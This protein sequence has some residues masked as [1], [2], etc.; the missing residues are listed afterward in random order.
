MSS[1]PP[2]QGDDLNF[3][4]KR[5]SNPT[6]EQQIIAAFGRP[7]LTK[8]DESLMEDIRAK[9]KRDQKAR[10]E[11]FQ[12][13]RKPIPLPTEHE[14]DVIL[15]GFYTT[16]VESPGHVEMHFV[17][18]SREEGLVF[19]LS[20]TSLD[21]LKKPIAWLTEYKENT[22][23]I[24]SEREFVSHYIVEQLHAYFQSIADAW[25]AMYTLVTIRPRLT[26]SECAFDIVK[27]LRLFEK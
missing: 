27:S 12:E 5:V 21:W 2:A 23:E 25:N 10:E 16:V 15:S 17:H 6:V 8:Y 11:Q 4:R 1:T 24:P 3:Y 22:P 7:K 9:E 14:M 13:L 19:D 26:D 20:C 18:K